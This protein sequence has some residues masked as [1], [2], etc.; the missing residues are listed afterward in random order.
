MKKHSLYL[1]ILLS[2]TLLMAGCGSPAASDTPSPT[3]EL[4]IS[5]AA[6]LTD[7]IQEIGSLY[8]GQHPDVQLTFNLA[9]SGTLQK[10]I[11]E[12][13]PAD[14]F[15]SA[16]KKQMDAL[17]EQGLIVNSSR[18][19]L[20][21][22]E[23]VLIAPEDS[24]LQDFAGLTDPAVGK[25]GIGT[26]ETVPAGKYAQEA[27]TSMGLWDALQPSLVQAKD[28]REVLTYVETGNAGA[29]LVY[30]SDTYQAEKIKIVATAP[31]SSHKPIVYP[32]AVVKSSS[33]QEAAA[34]FAKFLT[35]QEAADIFSKYGF[36]PLI[37]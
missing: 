16:G 9:S 25:I 5:A 3:I 29:G 11:E 31:N 7:A 24:L 2:I 33:K 22:N 21:G 37:K 28:V 1:I 19:D 15:I 20:L 12:G 6:S 17:Q 30:R 34:D 36:I 4:N 13:A 32:L 18:Q 10:Q 8:N 14:L 27:L 35:T 23:L 26:P